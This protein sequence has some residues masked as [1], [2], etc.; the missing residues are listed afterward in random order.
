[1][2]DLYRTGAEWLARQRTI[3][4]TTPVVYER[5][6]SS[7]EVLATIG[8]TVFEVNN[9]VGVVER[10]ESRDYLILAEHLVIDGR[11][12]LP[13]RGDRVRETHGGQAVVYEVMAP[14]Q[15]PVWRYSDPY[16]TT[17]RIHAKQVDAR[18]L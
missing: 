12:V 8:K 6:A 14:G 1:M 17:L 7:V 16:R 13:E 4:M 10:F 18:E 5:G 11:A 15:E 9:D 2:S 3:Y